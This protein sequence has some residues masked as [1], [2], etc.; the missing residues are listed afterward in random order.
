M[1]LLARSEIQRQNKQ[2]NSEHTVPTVA[3]RKKK[4]TMELQRNSNNNTETPNYSGE[5]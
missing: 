4:V 2:T 1:L 5:F 3:W